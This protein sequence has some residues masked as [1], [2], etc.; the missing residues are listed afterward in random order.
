MPEQL[1]VTGMPRPKLPSEDKR[2]IVE[3]IIKKV[4]IGNGEK[5]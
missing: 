5:L 4:V 1:H 3:A 2:K